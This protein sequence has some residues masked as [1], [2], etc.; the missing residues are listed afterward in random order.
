[1]LAI[2]RVEENGMGMD[3]AIILWV[4]LLIVGAL[5]LTWYLM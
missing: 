4:G 1:M 5:A 2:P 3:G